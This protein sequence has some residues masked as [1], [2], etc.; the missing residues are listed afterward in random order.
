[1]SG[2]HHDVALGT[3]HPTLRYFLYGQYANLFKFALWWTS[4]A[5]LT[6]ALLD[7]KTEAIG[8]GRICYNLA[9]C[10]LSPLGGIVAERV[11]PRKVLLRAAAVRFL[12]WCVLVPVLW[13]FF[14]SG[15]VESTQS[16]NAMYVLF[17]ILLVFDGAA[18]ALSTVLDIDLCG[19]DIM[20]NTYSLEVTDEHRNYFNSRQEFFFACCFVFFAPGMAFLGLAIRN[21]L[22]Q[23]ESNFHNNSTALESGTLTFIFTATF[24]VG[25]VAQF[26]FFRKFPMKED[27][28][29]TQQDEKKGLAEKASAV[30]LDTQHVQT[31]NEHD[32][33]SK[34]DAAAAPSLREQ[35]NSIPSD[36]AESIKVIW[37]NPPILFRLVFLGLEIAFE[38]AA[39]VV[40]ASQ[41]SIN[42]EWLGGKDSVHGNIWTA[43]AVASGKLGGAIASFGMMKFFH[44]PESPQKFFPLFLL[45]AASC[46]VI[47]VFPLVN[48]AWD[49][50]H[51]NDNA[52]RAIFLI[53]FFFYFAL[54]TLPKL[55]FMC[56]FQSMVAQVEN[57]PRVF[58]FI[59]II[60]TT[61][62]ALVI[63]ALTAVFVQTS[64]GTSLWVTACAYGAH[65]LLELVLG[66]ILVLR[67]LAA[68]QAAACE[69]PPATQVDE[70]RSPL[71]VT[72]EAESAPIAIGGGEY[73]QRTATIAVTPRTKPDDAGY[74]AVPAASSPKTASVAIRT[75]V[76]S[77]HQSVAY[78]SVTRRTSTLEAGGSMMRQGVRQYV[79]Q[80]SA[81]T[82]RLQP[83]AGFPSQ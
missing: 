53:A 82:P 77:S 47:F 70:H 36:L 29:S 81:L 14:V 54:S 40:I 19:L 67:P 10:I 23:G 42:L 5:P 28:E 12:I 8:V 59:A 66:P 63:M 6:F 50:G 60:A 55:G 46:A 34:E 1:M 83:G 65:G 49:N 32:D 15:V 41:M 73:T 56:L 37:A 11:H 22:R 39:I 64:I 58:G 71:V 2:E 27:D 9:L 76:M 61:F 72:S 38:D 52:A 80:G 75:A 20:A 51:V 74:G 3:I 44:P 79:R 18:V 21:G 31:E 45:V 57:G 4:L 17:N 48:D 43:V 78:G 26:Y 16:T 33:G 7:G 25:T 35:L 69:K 13:V 30:S 62:D 24:L 68:A